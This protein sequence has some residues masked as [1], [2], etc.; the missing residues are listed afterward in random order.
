[1]IFSVAQTVSFLSRGMTLRPGT[2][3]CMGSPGALTDP[4]PLLRPGDRVDV[5]VGGIGVMSNPVVSEPTT[6]P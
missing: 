4:R 5:E 1:M 2:V 6:S 3:I